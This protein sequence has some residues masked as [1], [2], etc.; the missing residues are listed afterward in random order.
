MKTDLTTAIVSAII[1]VAVAYFLCNVLLPQI[2]E[3]SFKTLTSSPDYTLR[4][5][6]VDIFNY[7]ALN[8]TVEVYVGSEEEKPE[9][10]KQPE[11]GEQDGASN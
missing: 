2:D 8:P 10:E 1:G 9:E 6:N 7:R 4:E 5:P 11:E 3:V